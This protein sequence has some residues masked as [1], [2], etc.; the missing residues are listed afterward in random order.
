M[1]AKT[2]ERKSSV[3]SWLIYTTCLLAVAGFGQ[4]E[5][6]YCILGPEK[7]LISQL[8]FFQSKPPVPVGYEAGW[9]CN[10]LLLSHATQ[11]GFY[12]ER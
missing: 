4:M 8:R 9:L 3:L 7:M 2:L 5:H 6:V 12:P 10:Y 11:I 1:K